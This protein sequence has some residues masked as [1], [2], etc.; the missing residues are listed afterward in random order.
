M[1]AEPATSAVSGGACLVDRYFPLLREKFLGI[2][3]GPWLESARYFSRT[4]HS[5]R[6]SHQW[7]LTGRDNL[8]EELARFAVGSAARV[9]VLVGRGGTGEAN[10]ADGCGRGA[11]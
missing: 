3:S 4:G 10:V 2:P 7:P 5:E 11:S 8:L 9:G 1:P 6:S